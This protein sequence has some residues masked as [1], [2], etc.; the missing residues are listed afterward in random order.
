MCQTYL[1]RKL[2]SIYHAIRQDTICAL[3]LYDLCCVGVSVSVYM[4]VCVRVYAVCI[5]NNN[6]LSRVVS[7][8]LLRPQID[9]IDLILRIR[10][11]DRATLAHPLC[12][13]D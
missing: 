2:N 3:P 5:R 4:G 11:H 8:V 10:N 13:I 6:A 9:C 12:S 7:D 1:C